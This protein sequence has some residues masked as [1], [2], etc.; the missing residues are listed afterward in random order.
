M[1]NKLETYKA[2]LAEMRA[3]EAAKFEAG[4][5]FISDPD[6]AEARAASRAAKAALEAFERSWNRRDASNAVL[7]A[8]GF[9]AGSD[10]MKALVATIRK[11]DAAAGL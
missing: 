4:L 10:E 5:V 1:T 6:N 8:S 11:I 7:S 3:L 2:K 9:A